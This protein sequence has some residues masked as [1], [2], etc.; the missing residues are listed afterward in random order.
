M[1][2]KLGYTVSEL[3]DGNKNITETKTGQTV[4]IG[5][6]KGNIVLGAKIYKMTSKELF[7]EA[8]ESMHGEHKKIG[9][10]AYFLLL[11]KITLLMSF[12]IF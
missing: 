10:N 4:T 12:Y 9:L 2:K 5:R 3:M 8:K 11:Q 1:V 7:S 6:M